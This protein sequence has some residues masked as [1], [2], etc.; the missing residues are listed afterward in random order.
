MQNHVIDIGTRRFEK[1]AWR[2]FNNS[3]AAQAA[4][5]AANKAAMA[6]NNRSTNPFAGSPTA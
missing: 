1:R 2:S 3:G 6:K 5:L 4:P